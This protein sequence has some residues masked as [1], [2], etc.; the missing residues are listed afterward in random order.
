MSGCLTQKTNSGDQ[1]AFG[2]A[3]DNK[4]AE[5]EGDWKRAS[6]LAVWPGLVARAPDLHLDS[7]LR[8]AGEPPSRLRLVL[9]YFVPPLLPVRPPI[10]LPDLR[11]TS[12]AYTLQRVLV[13]QITLGGSGH[14]KVTKPQPAR[15][16]HQPPSQHEPK[17]WEAD[18]VK[19]PGTFIFLA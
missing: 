5:E 11:G 10:S 7:V 14:E 16:Y 9:S 19:V 3:Q 6:W 2:T 1:I 18:G 15:Q 4:T 17:R 13:Y 8:G 12:C